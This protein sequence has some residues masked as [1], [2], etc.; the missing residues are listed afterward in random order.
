MGWAGL[1]AQGARVFC[2][3][4]A[5]FHRQE[6]VAVK[7][8]PVVTSHPQTA[9]PWLVGGRL[10]YSLLTLKTA[11]E[12]SS[13]QH[14]LMSHMKIFSPFSRDGENSFTIMQPSKAKRCFC[15]RPHQNNNSQCRI[16]CKAQV[17]WHKCS[18]LLFTLDFAIQEGCRCSPKS[19][20]FWRNLDSS[21]PAARWPQP[22][23]T[24][25]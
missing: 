13:L 4:S 22:G 23:G 3:L 11:T 16:S 25:L 2:G 8:I 20:S 6:T 17:I 24:A 15:R 21:P 5:I 19:Q 10:L 7:S 14:P 1:A 18:P 12:P 9:F